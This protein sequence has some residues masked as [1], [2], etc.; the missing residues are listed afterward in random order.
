MEIR[1]I[2]NEEYQNILNEGYVMED[3]RFHFRQQIKKSSFYNYENFSSDY[4]VEI[5]ES[6]FIVNWRIAF[7]LNNMGVENF[8]V[9]VD[10]IEGV[11]KVVLRDKQS[12]EVAQ[13]I[14]KNIADV[15]WR[16]I[17]D[18]LSIQ[19]GGTLYITDMDFDFNTKNCSV[20]FNGS[21]E[22]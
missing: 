17:V 10:S 6:D 22:Y 21:N 11:Y 7:W 14:D 3:D 5:N 15:P 16:F 13:E 19:K 2:I 20:T 4:D 1:D 8:L 18:D 12:D 9:Q